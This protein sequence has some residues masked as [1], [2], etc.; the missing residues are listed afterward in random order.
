MTKTRLIKC[1]IYS[2]G[3]FGTIALYLIPL[4]LIKWVEIVER[5]FIFGYLVPFLWFLTLFKVR[6]EGI[7]FTT[8]V[9]TIIWIICFLLTLIQFMLFWKYLFAKIKNTI[10]S[11]QINTILVRT[12]LFFVVLFKFSLM[13]L[14]VVKLALAIQFFQSSNSGYNLASFEISHLVKMLIWNT[15]NLE[16]YGLR[17]GSWLLYLFIS[18]TILILAF[19][20]ICYTSKKAI[21]YIKKERVTI[22]NH[23]KLFFAIS[24]LL[25]STTMGIIYRSFITIS[26]YGIRVVKVLFKCSKLFFSIIWFL[27]LVSIFIYAKK[28][29]FLK[30]LNWKSLNIALIGPQGSGRTIFLA[31]LIQNATNRK[32]GKLSN[33]KNISH[34]KNIVLQT[35]RTRGRVKTDDIGNIK[36]E[37]TSHYTGIKLRPKLIIQTSDVSWENFTDTQKKSKCARKS[38]DLAIVFI[39]LKRY[40]NKNATINSEKTIEAPKQK[41]L[42]AYI[43]M[44]EKIQTL[45]KNSKFLF[46]APKSN[47]NNLTEVELSREVPRLFAIALIQTQPNDVQYFSID[48]FV[49]LDI[50]NNSMMVLLEKIYQLLDIN[51]Y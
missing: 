14:L 45:S 27:F 29:F 51:C 7:V 36:L 40:I 32:I 28:L 44:I 12:L 1:I 49:A 20:I 6:V 48:S 23:L 10:N 26:V 8:I 21:H 50:R 42:L 19:P 35:S 33:Q 9:I 17:L 13:L 16:I 31:S 39:D 4:L 30:I 25:S 46:L 41:E 34:I 22:S 5:Y 37:I 38:I 3:L 11:T 2:A 24:W 15:F 18:Y 43:N 47:K